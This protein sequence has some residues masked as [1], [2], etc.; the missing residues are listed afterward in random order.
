MIRTEI[1]N[2]TGTTLLDV[3]SDRM[4]P[5]F[6]E[7]LNGLGSGN[8]KIPKK[9]GAL[10][11]TPALLAY[12]NIV[13][14][15]AEGYVAAWVI[16]K[17]NQ[18]IVGPKGHSERVWNV[19]G[20]GIG[21]KLADSLVYPEYGLRREAG[22][23]RYFTFVAANGEWYNAGLW[24][25]AVGVRQDA[26]TTARAKHPSGWPDAAAQWIWW[27]NPQ[28]SDTPRTVYIRKVV[29]TSTKKKYTFFVTADNK[30]EFYVDG[31]QVATGSDWKGFQEVTL[32]LE[33]GDHVFAAR[34]ENGDGAGAN[35]PAGF[36]MTVKETD[37]VIP[38]YLSRT[39]GTWYARREELSPLPGWNAGQVM[40]KLLAEATARGVT[41]AGAITKT[42][43]SANDSAG[44]PWP[45]VV[46]RSFEIGTDLLYV[47]QQLSETS[48]DWRML[49]DQSLKMQ[50]QI[51]VDRTT[52]SAP[53]ILQP[54]KNV[55]DLDYEGD[56]SGIRTTLLV[57]NDLA[58]TETS[59]APAVAA[60]GRREGYLQIPDSQSDNTTNQ[61]VQFALTQR[62]Q[63]AESVTVEVRSTAGAKP[64]VD[65]TLGD[66]V[67]APN[68]AGVM[69]KYRVRAI[70]V[71][72]QNG[73]I[74][75][76]PELSTVLEDAEARFNRWLKSIGNGTL[77]GTVA[78]AGRVKTRGG[79]DGLST[80]AGATELP[81]YSQD[82]FL[83]DGVK[84]SFT[85]PFKPIDKSD[86]V[87]INGVRH[88]RT[89]HYGMVGTAVAF[90]EAPPSGARVDVAYPYYASQQAIAIP[91]LIKSGVPL[92][93]TT[94]WGTNPADTWI[95]MSPNG[96]WWVMCVSWYG[97]GEMFRSP[98]LIN[99]QSIGWP[100]TGFDPQFEKSTT[101]RKTAI[102]NDGTVY[103]VWTSGAYYHTHFMYRWREADLAWST[104]GGNFGSGSSIY[105]NCDF[106]MLSYN[107]GVLQFHANE[108]ATLHFNVNGAGWTNSGG[109]HNQDI[110]K[111]GF[112]W[113]SAHV[114]VGS[115]PGDTT[116]RL[117]KTSGAQQSMTGMPSIGYPSYMRYLLPRHN[118]PN[119]L[120]AIRS[121]QGTNVWWYKSTDQGA[122]WVLS[123][124]PLVLPAV[125]NNG[126]S[127]W[128]SIGSDDRIHCYGY[129]TDG[130]GNCLLRESS[131]PLDGSGQWS[132]VR[133]VATHTGTAISTDPAGFYPIHSGETAIY[134]AG[135]DVVAGWENGGAIDYW[136]VTV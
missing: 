102:A 15:T 67:L 87:Y 61:V 129:T 108:E 71:G 66:W 62:K 33:A 16:E 88:T 116:R 110:I 118:V 58:L 45:N 56:G 86:N 103:T 6:M 111:A 72:E 47:L 30:Y 128:F 127:S 36:M 28:T 68:D 126:Y 35:N 82:A 60:E 29:T 79:Q 39:D 21:V 7:E 95:R 55:L 122:T 5:K 41:T 37:T 92:T 121:D 91:S 69:T 18:K 84:A 59:D 96:Q 34:V 49:H 13:K 43:T 109:D 25:L 50:V 114:L 104:Y 134:Q 106:L 97:G 112:V 74:V 76:V 3:L 124:G 22:K 125:G 136:R 77:G 42:W 130:S 93:G 105:R 83:A 80:A 85:L 53:V 135:V 107:A 54:A 133:T 52:G 10:V 65:W 90:T 119:E 115:P 81:L 1:F 31:Q 38:T 75:Y 78:S 19:S 2:K 12:G 24:S 17:K 113:T 14:M 100:Q 11:R 99:W 89:V 131:R 40:T 57:H 9:S 20:R 117:L 73:K 98:D 46:D 4:D 48:C 23:D 64:F 120:Y 27:Q 132:A 26:D 94:Q 8:F 123:A 32:V 44:V 101:G 51:G 70:T 63:A